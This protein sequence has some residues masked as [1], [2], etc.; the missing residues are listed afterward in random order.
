MALTLKGEWLRFFGSRDT[1][2]GDFRI[3]LSV[4]FGIMV[5]PISSRLARAFLGP[6]Y[7]TLKDVF[8]TKL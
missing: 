7:P 1:V 8:V 3:A 5:A 6:R 2:R 4:I